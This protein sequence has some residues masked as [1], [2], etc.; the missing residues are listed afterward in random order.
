MEK[1]QHY[2]IIVSERSTE[3]LIT[4]LHACGDNSLEFKEHNAYIVITTKTIAEKLK[5]DNNW[6]EK[7]ELFPV[8]HV[9]AVA[10]E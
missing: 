5:T 1:K 10:D 3:R 8:Y 9:I 2:R 7:V 6:I 4:I